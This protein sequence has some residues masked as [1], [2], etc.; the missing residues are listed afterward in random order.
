VQKVELPLSERHGFKTF[1]E[2]LDNKQ[3]SRNGI[4]RYERIFGTNFVS[5]GGLD[6]TEEFVKMLNLQ[7]GEHILDVGAGIGGGDF[8][9]AQTYNVFVTG[10]D[11]SSNMIS[12]AL[13]KANT[14]NDPRVQFEVCDATKR[15][16]DANTFDV[17]YSRDTI[18]HIDDKRSLF[19]SF[20]KW[21]KP[22]GRL[23]ISDYCCTSGEWS[24]R[25]KKYVAQR[26]YNLLS[27]DGYGKVLEDVGFTKVRAE[28][29]TD[30]FVCML[31]KELQRI[32]D[33]RDEFI[34]EF[35]ET[36]HKELVDGWNSKIERCAAGD[37]KWGL[38]Y[39]EKPASS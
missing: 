13:E 37:Q 14:F 39:A 7:P 10:I 9:M 25:Y 28:D 19:A 15:N 6:T 24:E 11:L 30:L 18:L 31:K 27:V 4:L 36:D 21:L 17:V 35:S 38:F 12:I 20:L 33:I 3:Y 8:Y 5:T 2:F 22:G 29:K 16:F 23:L 26:G 34:K 1:Q 32:D